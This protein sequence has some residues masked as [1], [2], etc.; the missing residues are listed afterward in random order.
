MSQPAAATA[1][2]PTAAPESVVA[3][4]TGR[5]AWDIVYAQFRKNWPALWAF[6]MIVLIYAISVCTPW[7]AN[8]PPIYLTGKMPGIYRRM[9]TEWRAAHMEFLR[10][11]AE[12]EATRRRWRDGKVT[13]KEFRRSLVVD[14]WHRFGAGIEREKERIKL[15]KPNDFKWKTDAVEIAAVRERLLPE[16]QADFDRTVARVTQDLDRVYGARLEQTLGALEVKLVA[17]A[18]QLDGEADAHAEAALRQYRSVVEDGWLNRAEAERAPILPALEATQK[19]IVAAFDPEQVTLVSRTYWPLPASLTTLDVLFMS[20]TLGLLVLVPLLL[21]F[22][23]LGRVEPRPR[24]VRLCLLVVLL[25][26]LP[27]TLYRLTQPNLFQ[28][29]AWKASIRDGSIIPDGRVVAPDGTVTEAGAFAT[30]LFHVGNNEQ[31]TAIKFQRPSAQHWFGTDENGRDLLARMLWGSRIS[32]AVGFVST[33]IALFIGIV[34]GAL[35]GYYRGMV[36]IVLSRVVEVIICFP[37]FFIILAVMAVLPP[38]IYNVMIVLGLFGWTGIAR[39]TRAEFLRLVD[40]DFVTAGRALGAG[41]LRMI[42]RHVL[43]NS[44]G[45]ILVAASFSVASAILTESGLSFLG[46]GVVPPD[47]SW[48]LILSTARENPNYWWLVLIPGFAIF[49]TV[50]LYNLLGEGIRDAIDPRMRV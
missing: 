24:K 22:T 30:A 25:V 31:D 12:L 41:P 47:T 38:S 26:V 20:A 21:R 7:L 49:V 32:L 10:T 33:G 18:S 34:L 39:L 11:P 36:D 50:T 8:D 4:G 15:E 37:N 23:R 29:V 16:E 42:F 19:T 28:S 46:F 35:A 17:L 27:P 13:M 40:S 2:T 3:A 45:P 9:F 5:S 48:G 44:L 1:A 43:P 14:D 6:R